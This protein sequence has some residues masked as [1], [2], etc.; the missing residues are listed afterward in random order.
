MK[1]FL[2]NKGSQDLGQ[3]PHEPIYG[4][5]SGKFT[6]VNTFEQARQAVHHYLGYNNVPHEQ[7]T[8]GH[9]VSEGE[10]IAYVSAEGNIWTAGERFDKQK[11]NFKRIMMIRHNKVLAIHN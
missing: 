6:V 8:G 4:T 2:A 1:I 3:N 11:E 10:I 9:I 7:F 5:I